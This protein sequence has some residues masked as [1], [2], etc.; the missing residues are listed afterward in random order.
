MFGEAKGFL[1]FWNNE[2]MIMANME[3]FAF[4]N[5]YNLRARMNFK[6]W[7]FFNVWKF[8]KSALK[9]RGNSTMISDCSRNIFLTNV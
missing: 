9:G 7:D 8:F 3:L 5:T 2:T 6:V 1:G 4:Q